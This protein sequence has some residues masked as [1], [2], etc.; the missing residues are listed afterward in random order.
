M[1]FP[2]RGFLGALSAAVIAVAI[3]VL[4]GAKKTGVERPWTPE[5]P[6][7][8]VMFRE[9][10]RAEADRFGYTVTLTTL[11]GTI[12]SERFFSADKLPIA[13]WGNQSFPITLDCDFIG[14]VR[15]GDVLRA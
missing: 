10:W 6:S 8:Y 2:R 12:L 11:D 7:G 9:T 3:E 14:N 1:T 15:F 13:T 4:P 5:E